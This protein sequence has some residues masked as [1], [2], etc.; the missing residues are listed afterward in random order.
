MNIIKR[1]LKSLRNALRGVLTA[2]KEENSFRIQL[3]VSLVVGVLIF[4]LPLR[5]WERSLLVLAIG[6]VLVLELLNSIVERFV[7]MV[8]PRM[9]D[10]VR[11]IKDL[12]A[13]AVLI[14]ALTALVLAI[15]IFWPYMYLLVRI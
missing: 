8:K 1:F 13:A 4:L 3:A 10:Y 14:T 15:I 12:S 11:Q 6:A 9:H 5:R 2:F 7:D